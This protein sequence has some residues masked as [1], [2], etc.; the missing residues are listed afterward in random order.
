[1]LHELINHNAKHL[2]RVQ[3]EQILKVA[4][5]FLECEVRTAWKGKRKN[6][7]KSWNKEIACFT[8]YK[9]RKKKD[10]KNETTHSTGA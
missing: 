3:G 7:L 8:R 4:E 2:M 1:M 10:T 9:K 6:K 5:Y